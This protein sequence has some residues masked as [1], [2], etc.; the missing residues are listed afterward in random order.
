MTL[1]LF[2]AGPLEAGS[3]I[4]LPAAAMR[5]VQV[6]RLQP[7]AALALFDGSGAEWPA[8][9]LAIGRA[10]ARVALGAS[11]AVARELPVAVTLA[12]CVPANERMDAL[13]EKAAELGAVGIVPLLSE[14]SVLRLDGERAARR[15]AHWQAIV[16]AA[17]EQCG[18]ARVPTVQPLQPLAQWL[19]ASAGTPRWLLSPAAAATPIARCPVPPALALLSG[20]EGGLS[21][22]EQAAARAGGCLP[23]SL[24]PRVLRADTA[25][26]AALAWIGLADAGAHPTA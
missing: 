15:R 23:V 17:C 9:V 3:E 1:R 24:G 26:L 2:V 10:S 13:V 4:D 21:E 8:Q 14:R 25:P 16:A 5:H 11:Q 20:P 12:V 7:G 19:A 22:A 18:R 6:R